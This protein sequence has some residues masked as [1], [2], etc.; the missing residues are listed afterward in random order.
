MV[1]FETPIDIQ[2]NITV[3]TIVYSYSLLLYLLQT[4][5]RLGLHFFSVEGILLGKWHSIS[6]LKML[7]TS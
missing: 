4:T 5:Q 3:L 1:G 2:S 7:S 6:L